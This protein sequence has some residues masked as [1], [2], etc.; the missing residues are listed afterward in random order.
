MSESQSGGP[1]SN[2]SSV[3]NLALA[4]GIIG[5][6]LG[7]AGFAYAVYIGQT[8]AS[9]SSLPS[10]NEKPTNVTV[11]V[12]W[13]NVL[14]SG[15]DRFNPDFFTV[16]QGDTVIIIF[17]TNDTTDAHTFTLGLTVGGFSGAQFVLNNSWPGVTSGPYIKNLTPLGNPKFNYTQFPTDCTNGTGTPVP[18]NTQNSPQDL[19]NPSATPPVNPPACGT[20]CSAS[21]PPGSCLSSSKP[22]DGSGPCTCNGLPNNVALNDAANCNLWSTGSFVATVPGVY[23]YFCFYHQVVGMFGYLTVLPNLAFKSS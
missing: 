14:N 13:L 2:S 12:E 15:Q 20:L 4:V 21:S 22:C 7:G 3:T 18:C 16:A 19:C 6:I 10:V 9:A 8:S 17:E 23:K 11:R 1:S 5:L